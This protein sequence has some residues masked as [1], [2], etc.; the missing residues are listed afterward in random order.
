MRVIMGAATS[1]TGNRWFDLAV[2]I[3]FGIYAIR[4]GAT[5]VRSVITW[6]WAKARGVDHQWE[7]ITRAPKDIQALHEAFEQL[8]AKVGEIADQ[9]IPN[10]GSSLYDQMETWATVVRNRLDSLA[11]DLGSNSEDLA[12]VQRELRRANANITSYTE[13]AAHDFAE[14]WEVLEPLGIDRR[15][16]PDDRPA[17]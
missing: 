10:H 1:S 9:L 5:V 14:I 8:S 11:R 6:S 13:I 2:L 12:A 17:P 15:D 3:A 4:N 16:A 7:G